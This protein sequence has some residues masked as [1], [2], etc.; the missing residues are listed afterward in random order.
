VNEV[1]LPS[2]RLK[3]IDTALLTDLSVIAL[4]WCV[5]IVIVNPVGDFPI[6]DDELYEPAVKSFLQTGHYHPPEATMTFLSNLLWGALFSLPAGVS[7]TAL[8]ISTL[9]ASLFG[10]FG[11]Y[12]LVRDLGQPR[13][14]RWVATLTLAVN[15]AYYALSNS[16]MTDVLFAVL[17]VW[18]AIFFARSLRGSS[19]LDL[20]LGTLVALGATLS[21]QIGL[22]IPLAFAV[23]VALRPGT[24]RKTMLRAAIPLGVCG[25][26]LVGFYHLLAATGRLPATY[27]LFTNQAISTFTHSRTLT[28]PI[29]NFYCTV[30]Y[31]GLLLLPVLLC[32]P[33]WL[34]RSASKGAIAVAAGV[35]V[36]VL[37]AAVVRA[38]LGSSNFMPLPEGHILRKNGVGILWLRGADQVPSL[39]DAFWICVTVLAF[40]GA[41]LLILQFS[42]WLL[43]AARS[44]LRRS[45]MSDAEAVT[46]FVLCCGV[47]LAVPYIGIRTTDR[48]LISCLP[49]LAAGIV[50]FPTLF[51]EGT[52]ESGGPLRY[53]TFGLLAAAGIFTVIGTRDYL[54]W[55]RVSAQASRDLMETGHIPAQSIDGGTEFDFL[56][57][58]P[59]SHEDILKRLDK[60]IRE[61]P[62]YFFT[63]RI[64]EQFAVIIGQGWRPS[65]PEYVVAFGPL[66]GYRVI[67]EYTD[68]NWMP[69]RVQKILVLQKE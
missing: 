19:D 25:V 9:C 68:D 13:W 56:Y 67:R 61:R 23:A 6:I 35:V 52:S 58:A 55:H 17:C 5:S 47:I 64:R 37:L 46:L 10:L 34:F 51:S 44:L 59:A 3:V 1:V 49:F 60:V 8:R 39:P 63:E 26:S 14:V 31:L 43:A 62:Q 15:P 41:A 57:P 42:V 16:Y 27:D 12:I 54:A 66:P 24:T 18:A 28:T 7:F 69:P 36:A 40:I 53:A 32:R 33:T 38:H 29:S 20:V 21:R 2:R 48:Y 4:L 45:P 50:S 22:A 65:S 30:V 11:V